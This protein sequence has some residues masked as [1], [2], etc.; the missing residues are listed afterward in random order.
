MVL[1]IA[2]QLRSNTKLT[3]IKNFKTM[4]LLLTVCLLLTFLFAVCA[5]SGDVDKK[6]PCDTCALDCLAVSIFRFINTFHNLER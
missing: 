4:K 3:S 1:N 5:F 6:D 2:S